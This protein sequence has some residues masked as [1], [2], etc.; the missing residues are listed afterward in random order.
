M[1][2]GNMVSHSVWAKGSTPAYALQRS[3][4][5]GS[6]SALVRSEDDSLDGMS[7]APSE[8]LCTSRWPQRAAS[9]RFS[10]GRSASSMTTAWI[11]VGAR[12][13][14]EFIFQRRRRALRVDGI[15]NDDSNIP[16]H[17]LRSQRGSRKS[18]RRRALLNKSADCC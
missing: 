8:S 13:G 16:R 18:C 2:N 14:R 15:Y 11:Y 3:I 12:F 17:C 6:A 7:V 9:R 1:N 10:D 4:G 5:V